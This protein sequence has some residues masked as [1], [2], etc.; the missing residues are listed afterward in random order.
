MRIP[1]IYLDQPM[2]AVANIQLDKRSAHYLVNV[3]RLREGAEVVLF[4]G[5]DHEF[6]GNVEKLSTK[7]GTVVIKEERIVNSESQLHTHMGIGLSRGER[8]DYVVQ[9]STELGVNIIQPLFTEFC[10]VKLDKK[11][12]LKK[13]EHWRL[14]SISASEQ[15]GRIR[16]PEIRKP[17]SLQ[18]WLESS[19]ECDKK[20]LLDHQQESVL[21]NV[22]YPASVAMLIGPE[23]GLSP[24]EK[25]LALSQGFDGIKLG[26][27]TLRTETA[28][29]AALSLFQFLWGN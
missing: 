28:P 19:L 5:S 27:R 20:F 3:L 10:E 22:F 4:N 15:C 17:V 12:E 23:G 13:L 16:P 29:V 14:V 9:K 26:S 1:R 24:K 8:M 21:Q 2:S 18:S 7:S 11:R 25:A 6:L